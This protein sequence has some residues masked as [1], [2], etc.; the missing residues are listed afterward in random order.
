MKPLNNRNKLP[1]VKSERHI[2]DLPPRAFEIIFA[3]CSATDLTRCSLVNKMFREHIEDMEDDRAESLRSLQKAKIF[4]C[5]RKRAI[6]EGVSSITPFR[7]P[8]TPKN[9]E[10]S[11]TASAS[12]SSIA[13]TS[14]SESGSLGSSRTK[15]R[16]QQTE[17]KKD[18]RRRNIS[19]R[20]KSASTSTDS[21]GIHSKATT[22]ISDQYSDDKDPNWA[23]SFNFDEWLQEYDVCD[24]Y[25]KNF[26][27]FIEREKLDEQMNPNSFKGRT[28][29]FENKVQ[30]DRVT[31]SMAESQLRILNDETKAIMRE[32]SAGRIER[33]AERLSGVRDA[34]FNFKDCVCYG[35]R[36]PITI[37]Y[38]LSLLE[39]N[40]NALTF[41]HVQGA[42]TVFLDEMIS[43]SNLQRLTVIQPQN[44]ATVNVREDLLIKWI[45]LDPKERKRISIHL[46]GCIEF[47]PEN[48]YN[49]VQEWLAH[50][51]PV[52]FK[53]IAIDG[54]SY[55]YNEFMNSIENLHDAIE[56]RPPRSPMNRSFGN[57]QNEHSIVLERTCKIP[58]PKDRSFMIQFKY[59][60]P[61]RRMVLT[62]EK[63]TTKPIIAMLSPVSTH[64]RLTRPQ[65]AAAVI[66]SPIRKISSSLKPMAMIPTNNNNRQLGRPLS[67]DPCHIAGC[68]DNVGSN[69]FTRIVSFLGTSS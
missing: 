53:Q 2:T 23:Y 32:Q 58:H 47:R 9:S 43:M 1:S 19:D 45:H 52:E 69:M 30:H 35:A 21:S 14:S 50:H 16:Q 24:V 40:F 49:F 28:A 42:S 34:H 67:H 29:F 60:K 36:P 62:I 7:L 12:S 22:F 68:R 8:R 51:E 37:F 59:C 10:S 46:V 13:S 5:D 65:S 4:I 6:L 66:T 17:Q 31:M 33:L 44:R 26:C 27:S 18:Q 61:S 20:T 38:F 41:D 64:H 54:G 56:K 3:H 39:K 57:D 63:G 25:F 15:T 55:K 11:D 48:L